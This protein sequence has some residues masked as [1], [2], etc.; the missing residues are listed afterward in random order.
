MTKV[1]SGPRRKLSEASSV[2][3]TGFIRADIIRNFSMN[4]LFVIKRVV[5]NNGARMRHVG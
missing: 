5:L 2:R 1:T 3:V 4:R